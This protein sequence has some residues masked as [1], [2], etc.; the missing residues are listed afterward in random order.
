MKE[1][2]D[3]KMKKGAAG[4][5]CE[6]RIQ[7][8]L[9]FVTLKKLNRLEKLRV[10]RSR[11][12]TNSSKQGVDSFNLQLQNLLYE[13]QF[14]CTVLDQLT[15]CWPGS[16]SEEGGDQMCPLQVGGRE[17]CPRARGTLLQRGAVLGGFFL[18]KL[19]LSTT[20]YLMFPPG[21]RVSVP[22]LCHPG[23][24]PRPQAGQAPVGARQEE[25]A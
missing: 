6:R 5:V 14:G 16:S 21:P 1:I 15:P 13:V 12:G 11:D 20:S 9:L 24:P 19:Y 10:K 17:S 25:G 2:F 18:N 7:A 4:D 23:R 3:L 8:S 22:G